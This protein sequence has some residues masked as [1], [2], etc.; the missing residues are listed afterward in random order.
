VPFAI[1]KTRIYRWKQCIAF[2]RKLVRGGDNLNMIDSPC[3]G[4]KVRT[5]TRAIRHVTF[6][7]FTKHMTDNK[8]RRNQHIRAVHPLPLILNNDRSSMY[9]PGMYILLNTNLYSL[10]DQQLLPT[11]G[12][13]FIKQNSAH[14]NSLF[15]CRF[16]PLLF[17]FIRE[18]FYSLGNALITANTKLRLLLSTC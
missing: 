9:I 11:A 5:P 15:C 6:V 13:N 8:E 7:S 10:T 18:Q 3:A 2:Y 1:Y 12:T 17:L 4:R 16:G 14:F